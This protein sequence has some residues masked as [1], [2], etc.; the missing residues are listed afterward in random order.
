M[1]TDN[2]IMNAGLFPYIDDHLLEFPPELYCYCGN[3]IGVW[4]YPNQF[5]KY[6][7][8]IH[9]IMPVVNT[10]VE[11]GVAAGGTFIFTNE[12][13]KPK[14]SYAVDISKVIGK[15]AGFEDVSSPYDGILKKYIDENENTSFIHG[16]SDDVKKQ[17]REDI[18][19]LFIDGDHSYEGVKR[20]FYTLKDNAKIFVFHD[21]VN[22]KCPGVIRF[23][24]E[25]KHTGN[26]KEFTDQYESVQG[27][28]LGIGVL[29]FK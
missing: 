15:P 6:L 17:V 9:E 28:Y 10:Y 23:W 20:D 21:I 22:Y 3:G 7:N 8:Y 29:S 25:I 2:D 18:D 13:L 12:V 1:I 11:I 4:Q 26:Y 19:I 24:N 5:S 14:K 16:T 27:V